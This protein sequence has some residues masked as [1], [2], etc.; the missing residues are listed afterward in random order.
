MQT[1]YEKEIEEELKKMQKT[2]E[3][4]Y[5]RIRE[6]VTQGKRLPYREYVYERA[7]YF[8]E[9]LATPEELKELHDLVEQKILK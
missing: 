5:L 2:L 6:A 8:V 9:K 3:P 1:N 7:M 4:E